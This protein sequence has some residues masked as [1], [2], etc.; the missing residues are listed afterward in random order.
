VRPGSPTDARP[1]DVIDVA[2]GTPDA[3]M[4]ACITPTFAVT[5]RDFKYSHP[6]FEHYVGSGATLGIVEPV[7][8]SDD[9]P[10]Y[11]PAG[12]TAVTTGP[13]EF[14]QW[15][16]DVANINVNLATTIPLH[17]V[18]SNLVFDNQ[19]FFPIDGQ[20][21]GNEG[22]PHNFAFTTELHAAFYYRGGEA[23]TFRG[24][25]DVWVFVNGHLAIDLGGVHTSLEGSVDLGAKS[26][27]FGLS[28]GHVYHF[29]LFQAERHTT[30]STFH[31]ETSLDC[32]VAR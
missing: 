5:T 16:H 4:P 20:G 13:A 32:F 22:A 6:D 18:G 8:G 27:D 12:A 26:A 19:Q 3:P 28:P 9:T 25:D 1:M 2:P 17:A 31:L 30:Q 7:L 29:D 15:Y 14:A 23:I 10:T 21:F 24:D 11:A